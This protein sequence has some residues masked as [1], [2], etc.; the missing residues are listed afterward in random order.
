LAKPFHATS[1]VAAAAVEED[2]VHPG[3]AAITLTAEEAD[4]RNRWAVFL[5][6]LAIQIPTGSVYAWSMWSGPLAQQVGVVT[7]SGMD[8]APVEVGFTFSCLA[9]GFGT[10]LGLLAPWAERVGPRVAGLVGGGLF[11]AGHLISAAGLYTGQLPLVWA[12]WGLVGGVG[13]GLG[14]ICPLSTLMRWFPDRKGMATGIS[15]GGFAGGALFGAPAIESL[16]AHFFE[17]PTFLGAADAV[18][19]KTEGARQL[20]LHAGEWQEAVVAT[21]S[22]ISKL[23]GEWSQ[24]ITEGVY[25]AGTGDTGTMMT[26]ATLGAVYTAS[27]CAG[28]MRMRAPPVGW[29]PSGPKA[30]DAALPTLGSLAADDTKSDEVVKTSPHANIGAPAGRSVTAMQAFKTPQFYLLWAALACNAS[31]GVCVISAAKQIMAD[32]FTSVNPTIVTATFCTGYVGALSVAN[33]AGRLGW[34]SLSDAI[35]R[36][37]TMF[38]CSLAMPACLAV[39]SIAHAAVDGSLPGLFPLAAFAGSTFALVT[40]YGGTLAL[41]PAYCADLFGTKDSSVIYGRIMTAW[42]ASAIATPTL[43][44]YLRAESASDAITDLAAKVDPAKFFETF[45]APMGDLQTLVDNKIVTV[46]RLMEICPPGTIDPTPFLYDSTFY[47]MVGILGVAAVSNAMITKVSEKHFENAIDIE[48]T[49]PLSTSN[50]TLLKYQ[51]D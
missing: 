34:A 24:T 3:K 38:I 15:I 35:G 36:K 2:D 44:G 40:W 23:P 29:L 43:L 14:Y 1:T 21:A 8:W 48:P 11:G 45:H 25:L 31:A 51:K 22:D 13:W 42:A 9:V 41:V 50:T 26:F 10:T 49:K 28:A 6:T 5:P 7:A 20:A 16:R 37:K 17:S 19:L 47:S 33:A 12:G 46:A 39:P 30:D 4:K 27:M 18:Q 32:V